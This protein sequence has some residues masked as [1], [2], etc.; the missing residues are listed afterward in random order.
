MAGK[1]TV[2]REEDLIKLAEVCGVVSAQIDISIDQA[3]KDLQTGIMNE[4]II[5]GSQVKDSVE[6]AENLKKNLEEIKR[7]LM[8]VTNGCAQV[9]GVQVEALTSNAKKQAN[10]GEAVSAAASKLKNRK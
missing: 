4:D 8:T 10:A 3:I 7:K 1:K 9:A 6:A 5:S 2:T